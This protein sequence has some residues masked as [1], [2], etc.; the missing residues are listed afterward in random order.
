MADLRKSHPMLAWFFLM[1]RPGDL[2]KEIGR[3]FSVA[4]SFLW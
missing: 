4:G 1:L 3:A 2:H